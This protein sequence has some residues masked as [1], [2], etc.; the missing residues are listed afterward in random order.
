MVELNFEE[1]I[2]LL[3]EKQAK[4]D[5]IAE[6]VS[7]IRAMGQGA[8]QALEYQPEHQLTYF[9]SLPTDITE[10]ADSFDQV[11]ADFQNQNPVSLEKVDIENA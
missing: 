1:A 9:Q 10:L 6:L 5:R 11:L 4:L 3:S 8:E 2:E 7:D